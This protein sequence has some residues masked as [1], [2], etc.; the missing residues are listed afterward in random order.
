MT[1]KTAQCTLF[2]LLALI[3][4]S[5]CLAQDA[6]LL[7]EQGHFKRAKALLEKRVA[8]NPKDAEAL[9]LLAR[10]RLK[11]DNIDEATKLAEQAVSIKPD[12]AEAHRVLGNCYSEKVNKV[13]IFQKM[14]VGR[15]IKS[16][17]EKALLLDPKNFDAVNGL[18]FFNLEAPSIV[19][20][21]K[22]KIP[23]LLNRAVVLDPVRGNLLK[24][25]LASRE[26]KID[27]AYDFD[28]EAVEAGPAT[29]LALLTGASIFTSAKYRDLSKAEEYAKKA[30]KIDPGRS[31]AYV[32]LAEIYI[33][34]DRWDDLDELLRNAE[35]KVPDDLN[36]FYQAGRLL[37]NTGKEKERAERY[38][39]KYLTQEPEPGLPTLAHA[40]WRLGQVLENEGKKQDAIHEVQAALNIKPD[41]EDAKKDLKRL[42]Q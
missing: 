14:G 23:E 33:L 42:T 34:K 41:L 22:D 36:P 7:I 30:L 15:S 9:V 5:A 29:Y 11:Y 26:K 21:S 10:V 16:E 37:L 4:C 18:V 8:S 20:A 13:S 2:S 40:H 39:R 6:A 31:A 1:R 12:Y 19:G 17:L 38:F 24:A 27:D 35:K 32:W 3:F 28:M 25:Q